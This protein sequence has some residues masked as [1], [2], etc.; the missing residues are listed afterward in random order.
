MADDVSVKFRARRVRMPLAVA[1]TAVALALGASAC[2]TGG[3]SKAGPIRFNAAPCWG[4]L[5]E[6]DITSILE[7]GKAFE[8]KSTDLG[9]VVKERRTSFCS[10]L[11]RGGTA[12]FSAVAEWRVQNPFKNPNPVYAWEPITTAEPQPRADWGAGAETWGW[13]TRVAVRCDAAPDVGLQDYWKSQKF[14]SVRVTGKV[15]PGVEAQQ[16]E[17]A[18]ADMAIKLTR[19][20]ARKVGCTND[21]HL[22]AS[23]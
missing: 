10:G 11:Q 1:A 17:R 23:A 19:E 14:L 16:G 12:G 4:L 9:K 3:E 22:P 21:L 7:E 5:E 2:G 6:D 13:G 15:A 18:I 8:V 20:L